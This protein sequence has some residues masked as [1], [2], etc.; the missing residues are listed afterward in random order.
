MVASIEANGYLPNW[1]KH[2]LDLQLSSALTAT[3]MLPM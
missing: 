3:V 2:L 1:L